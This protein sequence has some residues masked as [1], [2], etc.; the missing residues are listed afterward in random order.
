MNSQEIT[1]G[2][3]RPRVV[4]DRYVL[5]QFEE[6]GIGLTPSLEDIEPYAIAMMRNK[7]ILEGM[8]LVLGRRV[9]A[10]EIEEDSILR[11]IMLSAIQDPESAFGLLLFRLAT[12][13]LKA[14]SQ[15]AQ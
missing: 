8:G 11:G 5:Q 13:D 3:N 9:D 14:E 15:T 7:E 6:L 4:E 2:F 1:S 12:E 10:M